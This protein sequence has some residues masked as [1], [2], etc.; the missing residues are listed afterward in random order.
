MI[1]VYPH[2][3][4]IEKPVSVFFERYA[5]VFLREKEG[6]KRIYKTG[7]SQFREMYWFVLNESSHFI[8][9]HGFCLSMS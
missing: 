8:V 6:S 3:C 7:I 9:K 2:T 4:F 5:A 1:I